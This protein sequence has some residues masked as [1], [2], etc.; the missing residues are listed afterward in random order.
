[1][2]DRHAWL[3]ITR[4]TPLLC[5]IF[6][7]YLGKVT[8]ES[9]DYVVTLVSLG[10]FGLLVLPFYWY[11]QTDQPGVRQTREGAKEFKGNG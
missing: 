5:A 2:S 10:L 4:V 1:M 11:V 8:L 3:L 6:L 9:G 7:L